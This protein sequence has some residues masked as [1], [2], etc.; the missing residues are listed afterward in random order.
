MKIRFTQKVVFKDQEG[1][2]LKTY[3]IGDVE[4][5]AGFLDQGQGCGYFITPMGG[6]YNNEAEEI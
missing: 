5:A 3:E 4:T 1:T 2:V 6:I